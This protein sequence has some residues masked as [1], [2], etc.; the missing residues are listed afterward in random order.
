MFF[1]VVARRTG[2][3]LFLVWLTSFFKDKFESIDLE[4]SEYGGGLC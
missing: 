2:G 1:S 3:L 4:D